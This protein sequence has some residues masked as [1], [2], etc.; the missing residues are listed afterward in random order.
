[1]ALIDVF[2]EYKPFRNQ[3]ALLEREESLGVIWAY[4][5][6]LQINQFQ[7]PNDIEVLRAFVDLKPRQ[8]WIA[9]WQ[10][11]IL[12]KEVILNSGA[13]GTKGLTLRK[14]DTLAEYINSLKKFEDKI[15]AAFG[16]GQNILIELIRIAHQQFIWQ[17]SPPNSATSMRY[18]KIFNQAKI[19]AICVDRFGLTVQDIYLCGIG[20]MSIFLIHPATSIPFK[21]EIP[22]LPV[23]KLEKFLPFACRTLPEM[24]SILKS[25]QQYNESYAY[26]YS[27][28]RAFPLIR[29][30]YGGVDAI[31]CPLPTLLFWK[32]TGGLY[33]E[34]LG[35]P[36]FSQPFGDSFQRYVG[37]VV[38]RA[39]PNTVVSLFPEEEY[40]PKKTRRRTVDW[41]VAEV[42]S[43]IF[44]ECKAKRLSWGA[45]TS[46][47]DLSP[48]EGDIESM[49]T[50]VVQVY[51]T[52]VDYLDNQYPQYPFQ[53]DRNIYPT[54]V[55]L[56]SWRMFGP[57]MLDRLLASVT[58]KIQAAEIPISWLTDMPY[59]VIA[60][61]D[62]EAGMQIVNSVGIRDFFDGKV[63]DAEMRGWD[64]HGYMTH[65]YSKYFP[66]KKLFDAEY[67][68][69]FEAFGV[70][71]R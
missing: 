19:D 7:M 57:A 69:L 16:S 29:M 13:K 25:E 54:V 58:E 5:Q 68:R 65:R 6:Y 56:E 9:E 31:V 2:R 4:C 55:T 42:G 47:N 49:A 64:W 61:E 35:D 63:R 27:S 45:K 66:L 46:L 39:C 30:D 67:D 53:A 34:L 40:G 71:M 17:G 21:S 22:S 15:A 3:T 51:K 10:L 60:V 48:L 20:F 44:L 41:I 1:M 62:L 59:S 33:Y 11:E 70:T 12:A 32:I 26:A 24:K 38:R 37:D 14:W 43:A 18:F 52:I 50:A 36:R 8:Q 28:L 23:E